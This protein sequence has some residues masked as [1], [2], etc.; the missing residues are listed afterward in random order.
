MQTYVQAS[1]LADAQTARPRPRRDGI[2]AALALA[3]VFALILIGASA[4]GGRLSLPPTFD[5]IAYFKDALERLD[6]LRREGLAGL[7]RHY[8]ASPP[9]SPFS[10]RTAM[11]G[12]A[13]FG[14]HL[15]APYVANGLV[16]AVFL[17]LF[18]F[19]LRGFP[20]WAFSYWRQFC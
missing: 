17:S 2:V 10:T 1:P 14:L 20:F 11:L 12:F 5:D 7:L 16:L 3:L 19:S 8:C 13:V 15:W 6:I 4:V 9:H 18:F